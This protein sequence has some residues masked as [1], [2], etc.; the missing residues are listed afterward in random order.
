ML[1]CRVEKGEFQAELIWAREG[2]NNILVR[3]DTE[4]YKNC[5]KVNNS[6]EEKLTVNVGDVVV[7]QHGK[8]YV[9]LGKMYRQWVAVCGPEYHIKGNYWGCM[10]M[11][12]PTHVEVLNDDKA[13]HM[14]YLIHE[15]YFGG[16]NIQ[17]R[18]KPMKISAIE[19]KWENMSEFSPDVLFRCGDSGICHTANGKKLYKGHHYNLSGWAP[20]KGHQYYHSYRVRVSETPF[21][22][23]DKPTLEHVLNEDVRIKEESKKRKDDYW[24]EL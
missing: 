12:T 18:S 3:T 13:Y 23:H 11:G 16:R 15:T 9:Y 19:G 14:Y 10:E 24:T 5:V 1:A 20:G 21:D 8:K 4:D 6:K 17:K 7:G 2:A 22:K